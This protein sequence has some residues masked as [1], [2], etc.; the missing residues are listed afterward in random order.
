MSALVYSLIVIMVVLIVYIFVDN[1]RQVR[2]YLVGN[3]RRNVTFAKLLFNVMS[4]WR[5][6]RFVSGI[7]FDND[8]PITTESVARLRQQDRDNET[9]YFRKSRLDLRFAD[10]VARFDQQFAAVRESRSLYYDWWTRC[11]TTRTRTPDD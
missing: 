7:E 3:L 4:L 6:D 1:I 8:E 5:N 2:R 11:V 10:C 9:E